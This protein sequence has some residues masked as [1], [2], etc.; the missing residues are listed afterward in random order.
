MNHLNPEA[1]ISM[2]EA[3]NKFAIRP[4]KGRGGIGGGSKKR[5]DG[6]STWPEKKEPSRV[7]HA[8]NAKF[9]PRFSPLKRESRKGGHRRRELDKK[10]KRMKLIQE[11][12]GYNPHCQKCKAAEFDGSKV[13]LVPDHILTR[14][15]K[16]ADRYENL[17]I[18]CWGCNTK[19]GSVREDYRPDWFK[20]EMVKLDSGM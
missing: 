19:K 14:N 17:G 1:N 8:R 15:E 13:K 6:S 20:A 10:L 3:E 7:L 5:P 4:T 16:N 18:L 12:F 9:E 2:S 11:L